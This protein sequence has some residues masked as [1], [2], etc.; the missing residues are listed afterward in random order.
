MQVNKDNTLT[1]GH[2]MRAL[3]D[4]RISEDMPIGVIVYGEIKVLGVVAHEIH[5]YDDGSKVFIAHTEKNYG[6]FPGG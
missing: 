5:T 4:G 3:K 1:V 6:A 2:L